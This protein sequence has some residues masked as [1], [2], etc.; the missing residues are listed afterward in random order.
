MGCY[1][2]YNFT[3]F[4][5]KLDHFPSIFYKKEKIKEEKTHLHVMLWNKIS[6]EALNVDI[7]MLTCLA[8]DV[9]VESSWY[10]CFGLRQDASN[11]LCSVSPTSYTL[12]EHPIICIW[13]MRMYVQFYS[14]DF[15]PMHANIHYWSAMCTF[16][17]TIVPVIIIIIT[18]V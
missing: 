16:I 17:C 14:I 7:C 13:S 9:W 2:L 6:F 1:F 11:I 8:L 18:S 12:Q 10:A 3:V 15:V 5:R 4:P